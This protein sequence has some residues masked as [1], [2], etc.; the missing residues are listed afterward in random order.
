MIGCPQPV[1]RAAFGAAPIQLRRPTRTA[2]VM[3]RKRLQDF[4]PIMA[5]TVV[6]VLAAVVALVL[7]VSAAPATR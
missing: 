1:E 3:L 4:D 7:A 5:I 6:L 2:S